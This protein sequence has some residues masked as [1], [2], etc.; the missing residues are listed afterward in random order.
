MNDV[1]LN[2]SVIIYS[3]VYTGFSTAKSGEFLQYIIRKSVE[4]CPFD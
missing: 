3:V 1:K 2:L 4:N